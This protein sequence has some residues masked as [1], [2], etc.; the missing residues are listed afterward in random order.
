MPHAEALDDVAVTKNA[1]NVE[2]VIGWH[3]VAGVRRMEH[4][5]ELNLRHEDHLYLVRRE[6][7]RLDR[8]RRMPIANMLTPYTRTDGYTPKRATPK[9][10]P[11]R[12]KPE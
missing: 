6:D 1:A 2:D 10:G 11:R 8:A 9:G 4:R 12:T 7:R 3:G 5:N